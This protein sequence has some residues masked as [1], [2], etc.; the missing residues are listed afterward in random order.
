MPSFTITTLRTKYLSEKHQFYLLHRL[1]TPATK[2]KK[3][4][5]GLTTNHHLTPAR[6]SLPHKWHFQHLVGACLT[7]PYSNTYLAQPTRGNLGIQKD[8]NRNDKATNNKITEKK[9][10]EK[11]KW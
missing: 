4:E 6:S 10:K 9:R 7:N 1:P 5:G 11:G 2:Q 3:Q 8:K